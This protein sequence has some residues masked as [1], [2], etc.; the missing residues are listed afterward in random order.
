[1][2][3][4]NM[5]LFTKKLIQLIINLVIKMKIDRKVGR[6]MKN[7]SFLYKQ[8]S[9]SIHLFKKLAFTS[10]KQRYLYMAS[11]DLGFMAKKIFKMFQFQIKYTL[12]KKLFLN[13]ILYIIIK[14]FKYENNL[15]IL[16]INLLLYIVR[17]DILL[18][19]YYNILYLKWANNIFIFIYNIEK[20]F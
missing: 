18:S 9:Y 5:V 13:I 12:L 3:E 14:M 7:R 17:I 10:F 20:V 15:A 16:V 2:K 6:I 4:Q 8:R 1:M 11:S 19:I